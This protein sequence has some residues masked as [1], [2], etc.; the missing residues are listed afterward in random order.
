MRGARWVDVDRYEVAPSA[1]RYEDWE[2]P[3]ALVLGLGSAARYARQVGI[4]TAGRRAAGLADQLRRKLAGIPGVR[5]FDR[6][7]NPC[8]IVTCDVAGSSG[9]D[10]VAGL[11]RRNINATASL[12]WY[13]LYDFTDKRVESVVR[14]SPHYY[15]TVEEIEQ[16][17]DLIA[18]IAATE[19]LTVT[20]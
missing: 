6:G 1:Q 2:F 11:A 10:V 4:E 16:A 13:G 17:V 7:R 3:Y 19:T 14:F 18:E 20:G 12:R 5:V 8:A 15:N 9:S